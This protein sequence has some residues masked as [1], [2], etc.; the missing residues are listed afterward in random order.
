MH[1]PKRK[2][3]E[4][5]PEDFNKKIEELKQYGIKFTVSMKPGGINVHCKTVKYDY[6]ASLTGSID[7]EPC[8]VAISKEFHKKTNYHYLEKEANNFGYREL[9]KTDGSTKIEW[10]ILSMGGYRWCSDYY[11]KKKLKIWSYDVNSS[12]GYAMLQQMPDTTKAPK[13]NAT[14]GPNEMGFYLKGGAT[15]KVGVEADI[16]FPLM[17]SP[18]KDYVLEKYELKKNAPSGSIDRIAAKYFLN[19]PTGCIQRHN[20]FL[21]NAILYYSKQYI[22][23]YIDNDTVYCNVDSIYSLTPRFDLP[24][25][26][27]IGQFKEE[28]VNADFKYLGIGMY[29]VN[30]ECHY[31]GINNNLIV[32]ISN[33]NIQDGY[34][35]LPWKF[36]FEES[37]FE[38]NE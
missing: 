17:D 8:V 2:R 7:Y 35:Y 6:I 25:G 36:N 26:D 13:Y 24:I 4:L 18:F 15:R 21:R 34:K 23:K 22:K 1:S 5:S 11:K 32:D 29:E 3:M 20:I 30:G 38:K 14:V 31:L 33:I 37:R 10:D 9:P 28:Y 19:I 27:N 16:V 12:Y